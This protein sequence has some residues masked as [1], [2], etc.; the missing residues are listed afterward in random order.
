MAW[1][2][3]RAGVQLGWGVLREVRS[4]GGGM[5]AQAAGSSQPGLSVGEWWLGQRASETAERDDRPPLRQSIGTPLRGQLW[6]LR[7]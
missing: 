1:E 7:T 6:P 2:G 5:C 3:C 4:C